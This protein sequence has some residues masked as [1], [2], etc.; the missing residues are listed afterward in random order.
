[1]VHS[2][3]LEVWHGGGH[4]Q[5]V[6]ERLQCGGVTYTLCWEGWFS[7]NISRSLGNKKHTLF[8]SDVWLGGVSFRVR[9][10]RLYNLSMF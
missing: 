3:G 9:F 4:I 10:S 1:M 8:W 6:A 5:G 7:D 2:V